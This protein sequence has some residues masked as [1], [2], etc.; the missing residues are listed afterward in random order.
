VGLAQK[1]LD[2]LMDLSAE[3]CTY[4]ADRVIALGGGAA[5]G[6]RALSAASGY[7]DALT[8]PGNNMGQRR[9]SMMISGRLNL[10]DQM[11]RVGMEQNV[12]V[13]VGYS[14]KVGV[15]L[16]YLGLCYI[17]AHRSW[18]TSLCAASEA[19]ASRSRGKHTPRLP[20]DLHLYLACRR[21]ERC[22]WPRWCRRACSGCS[23]PSWRRCAGSR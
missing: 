1:I 3:M 10:R 23:A 13:R 19:S 15:L 12:T 11:P 9:G 4:D 6:N 5:G 17:L 16:S 7:L 18:A 8:A 22:G 14:S 21:T 2:K 20:G